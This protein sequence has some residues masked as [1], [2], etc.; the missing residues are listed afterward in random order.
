MKVGVFIGVFIFS[1]F[2]LIFELIDLQFFSE[3]EL[4]DEFIK[5]QF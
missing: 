3:N 2:F 1:F 5:Y 4:E